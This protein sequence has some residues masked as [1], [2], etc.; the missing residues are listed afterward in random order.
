MSLTTIGSTPSTGEGVIILLENGQKITKNIETSVDVNDNAQY[1]H[2][3]FISLT[4]TDIELLKQYEMT[5]ARLYIFDMKIKNPEQ[6]LG[7]I[8]CLTEMK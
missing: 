2:S 5:D 7:Y 8:N 3:A 6:Y 4:N 1:E